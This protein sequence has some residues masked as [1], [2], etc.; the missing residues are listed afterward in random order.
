MTGAITFANTDAAQLAAIFQRVIHLF[1]ET[2]VALAVAWCNA[3]SV[4]AFLAERFADAS[5]S[6]FLEDVAIV[7]F[8]VLGCNAASV[9][10]RAAERYATS[11]LVIFVTLVTS[12][13]VWRGAVT[14]STIVVADGHAYVCTFGAVVK[15]WI[16]TR[17]KI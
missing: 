8:A 3:F 9:L 6:H 10:A 4:L 13:H 1:D 7:A 12:A 16:G 14:I 17:S 15:T 2:N 11:S 5:I